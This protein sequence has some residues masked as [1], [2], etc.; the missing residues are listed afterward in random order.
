[1]YFFNFYLFTFLGGFAT[2]YDAKLEGQ[3]RPTDSGISIKN[4]AYGVSGGQHERAVDVG[5]AGDASASFHAGG[6][7]TPPESKGSKFGIS[8]KLGKGS[9]DK[10]ARSSVE[11]ALKSSLDTAG[12]AGGIDS[13]DLTVQTSSESHKRSKDDKRKGANV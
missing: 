9:K 10:K 13:G 1:L 11:G 12:V 2:S 4:P 5:P 8:V 3:A 7:A 6:Q